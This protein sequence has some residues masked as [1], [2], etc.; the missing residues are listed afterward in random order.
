[1]RNILR[2]KKE[3]C[4]IRYK[5]GSVI[6]LG[7]SILAL[8]IGSV[9]LY[10]GNDRIVIKG[11]KE[12]GRIKI[13]KTDMKLYFVP[14]ATESLDGVIDVK[15]RTET[16]ADKSL[17]GSVSIFSGSKKLFLVPAESKIDEAGKREL[18]N[19]LDFFIRNKKPEYFRSYSFTDYL[20]ALGFA[21][22]AGALL[23]F[24]SAALYLLNRIL[25]E[26][27][28]TRFKPI[29]GET[30][31]AVAVVPLKSD[32]KDNVLNSLKFDD[33]QKIIIVSDIE[34][35]KQFK[36]L[37]GGKTEFAQTNDASSEVSCLQYSCVWHGKIT[38][39][40]IVASPESAETVSEGLKLLLKEHRRSG[41]S[42]TVATSPY[43]GSKESM[44]GIIRN[45]VNKISGFE[46]LLY[47]SEAAKT[48]EFFT[49][50]YCFNAEYLFKSLKELKNE[51]KNILKISEFYIYLIE[52]GMKTNSCIIKKQS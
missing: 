18:F 52:K 6:T 34:R 10:Y 29:S 35:K 36:N 17:A 37:L 43:G 8:A 3:G 39:D 21:L 45:K 46:P 11:I 33:V 1:L 32:I 47:S 5:D 13:E 26:K 16:A 28:R 27:D 41:N 30:V 22:A 15:F 25:V 51:N 4:M 38:G 20:G 50:I 19:D 23:S 49:G 42:C 12:S 40:I 31:Y 44:P 24:F 14:V 9:C 7:I 2:H 48:G